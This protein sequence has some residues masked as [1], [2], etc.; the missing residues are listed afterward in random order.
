ME[1]KTLKY[2][3]NFV[4]FALMIFNQTRHFVHV[5]NDDDDED[6]DAKHRLEQ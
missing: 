6:V 2:Y 4:C 5:Y 1:I 3:K